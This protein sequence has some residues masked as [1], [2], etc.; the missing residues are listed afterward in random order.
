MS[1]ALPQYQNHL[2]ILQD[3]Q[4]KNPHEQRHKYLQWTIKGNQQLIEN[5]GSFNHFGF[6]QGIESK[7]NI[8]RPLMHFT[9]LQN[10]GE[11]NYDN[12]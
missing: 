7:F 5:I 2:V 11:K 9:I 12:F 8:Q 3:P 1:P 4:T 6:I 10:K